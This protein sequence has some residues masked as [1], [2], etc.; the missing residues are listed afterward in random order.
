VQDLSITEASYVGNI[1]SIGACFWSLI[2]GL[3]I[4]WSGRFKWIALYFGLP[5]TILGVAL[6]VH[7]RQP[8]QNI[9]Y[10]G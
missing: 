4:R 3:C 8:N 1:Y 10:I 5:V 9:G 7:F 6:M 2:V